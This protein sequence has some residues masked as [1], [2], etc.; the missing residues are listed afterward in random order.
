MLADATD[1]AL[2]AAGPELGFQLASEHHLAA[3]FILA[4]PDG[5]S[6][7]ERYTPEFEPFLVPS[8]PDPSFFAA[9]PSPP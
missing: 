7:R 9:R 8:N 3:F 1:T 4:D 5:K 6:F 2:L